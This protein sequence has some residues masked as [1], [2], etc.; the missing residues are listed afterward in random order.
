MTAT[1]METVGPIIKYKHM[2]RSDCEN[3]I[4]VLVIL[5]PLNVGDLYFTCKIKG[6]FD[7]YCGDSIKA[8]PAVLGE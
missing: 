3:T 4:S 8:A 1:S 7:I 5:T 6:L 2:A